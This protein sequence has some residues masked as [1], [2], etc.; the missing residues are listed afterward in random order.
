TYSGKKRQLP[1]F[2]LAALVLA[3]NG[4]KICMQGTEGH[5]EGR[6]YTSEVLNFLGMPLAGSLDDAA[7]MIRASNFAYLPLRVLSPKLQDI[8]ELKSVIGVRSPV[9]T[10]ARMINPFS[11]PYEIH[12]VF[13]PNY[14]DVHLETSQLLGQDHMAV[15]KGEGGEAERRPNKPVLVQSL[16][17]GEKVDEEWPPMVEDSQTEKDETLDLDRFKAVWDGEIEDVYATNAVVG[18]IAIALRLM[19]RA[20]SIEDAQAGAEKMWRDRGRQLPGLAA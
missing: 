16:R 19:Q 1:W 2:L 10:F 13:H 15:F 9:N 11:A 3:Q 20:D 14:R 4:V 17:D 8:I 7:E 12:T 6:L 5:T 18:T